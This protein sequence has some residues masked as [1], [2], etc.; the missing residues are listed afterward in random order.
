[1]PFS[2]TI[3][4]RSVRISTPTALL[5]AALTIPARARG[6]VILA[7]GSGEPT[8]RAGN[9]RAAELLNESGFA[10]LM[11]NLLGGSE[12]AQ[13]A[14]TSELRFD[15][16]LLAARVLGIATWARHH[17]SLSR[18]R[19]AV[20]AGGTCAA[21]AL[22]ASAQDT[23]GRIATIVSRSGRP[24][25][26]GASL[27][28]VRAPTLLIVGE[29]DA[30]NLPTNQRAL[31]EL[32]RGSRIQVVPGAHHLLEE[33]ETAEHAARLTAAWLE[34]TC[35]PAPAELVPLQVASAG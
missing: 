33:G 29:L 25:L 14:E 21:A 1:M 20:V 17:P 8:Y 9:R 30:A 31:A 10:T 7:T 4:E 32:P 12:I 22:V 6:L 11:V 2:T 16:P 23:E 3:P 15:L 19:V 35:T 5:D 26:A 24:E 34:V 28:R 27:A 13:D 18:L